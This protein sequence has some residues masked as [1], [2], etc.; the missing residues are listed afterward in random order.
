MS[1]ELNKWEELDN[2]EQSKALNIAVMFHIQT[3]IMHITNN[4]CEQSLTN[5]VKKALIL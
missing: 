3:K 5:D 2:W 4:S 1:V